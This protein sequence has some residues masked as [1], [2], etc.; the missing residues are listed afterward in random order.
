MGDFAAKVTTS[1]LISGMKNFF[2]SA[3]SIGFVPLGL[4]MHL[5]LTAP[6]Y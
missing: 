2:M 1:V 4:M 6:H 3:A 5:A